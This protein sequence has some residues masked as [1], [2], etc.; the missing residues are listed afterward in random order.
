MIDT[1]CVS[2]ENWRIVSG[3]PLMVGHN[4]LVVSLLSAATVVSTIVFLFSLLKLRSLSEQ[5]PVIRLHLFIE[6]ATVVWSLSAVFL[7]VSDTALAVSFWLRVSWIGA[8]ATSVA[9]PVF[10]LTYLGWRDWLTRPPVATSLLLPIATLVAL[11]VG[12][13]FVVGPLVIAYFLYITVLNAFALVELVR[14]IRTATGTYRWQTTLLAVAG[15]I[16]SLGGIVLAMG[17]SPD[18]AISLLPIVFSI[19]SPTVG[20]AIFRYGLFDLVPVAHDRIFEEMR[21]GVI[22]L[23]DRHRLVSL[24]STA[25]RILDTEGTLV[26]MHAS[27]AFSSYPALIAALDGESSTPF[28]LEVETSSGRLVYDIDVS[29]VTT[30][31]R[32]GT[33]LIVVLRDVTDRQ[34]VEHRY[35]TLIER[36]AN[37]IAI[38]DVHGVFRYASPSH[39]RVLGYSPDELLGKSIFDFLHPEDR[40]RVTAAFVAGL[41]RSRTERFECRVR[42]AD[43]SWRTFECVGDNLIDDPDIGGMVMS[44]YDVTERQRYEQRLQVLNR[45]LRHDLRNDINVIEGYADLLA[46]R[47]SDSVT[48]MRVNVI[49]RKTRDLLDLSDKARLIDYAFHRDGSPREPVE[50]VAILRSAIFAIQQSHRDVRIELH[51]PDNAWVEADPLIESA[52]DNVLENAVEHND[53]DSPEIDVTVADAVVNGIEYVEVRVAD[54]GPRIPTQEQAVLESGTETQLE[55]T[56]GLGLWLTNWLVTESD[57]ELRLEANE[58]RG[59]VVII[60]LPRLDGGVDGDQRDDGIDGD[61]RAERPDRRGAQTD[62][63]SSGQ[64]D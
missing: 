49:E 17:L 59:N 51:S 7:S 61:R 10:V 23:D 24:N 62:A 40:D 8:V 9:W 13:S 19:V 25:E 44:A 22:V 41:D 60:R 46:E 43:G 15:A 32:P 14:E 38:V 56:S 31:R 4:A 21:D 36:T 3:G 64:L 53:T 12:P 47:H 33:G 35:K 16:P 52:I 58:S 57:G 39:E 6:I 45:V 27:Q 18:A 29:T 34:H 11:W 5:Q 2:R 50:F 28:E 37:T 20:L 42:H 63:G 48:Q 1:S 30:G 55:H 26:G 54:N